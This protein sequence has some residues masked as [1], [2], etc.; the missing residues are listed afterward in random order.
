VRRAK[1]RSASSSSDPSHKKNKKKVPLYDDLPDATEESCSTFQVIP[2]CLYGSKHMGSTDVDPLDCDCQEQ[3]RAY[4]P[5][6]PLN[7]LL[8]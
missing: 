5:I 6:S 1:S 2:E 7:E 8:N 3:W 4:P